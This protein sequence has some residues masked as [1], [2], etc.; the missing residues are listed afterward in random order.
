MAVSF[1]ITGT[2]TG[3]GKTHATIALMEQFKKQGYQVAGMKP[4]ASGAEQKN[5]SLINEDAALI[6]NACSNPTDYGLINPA[7][8]ELPVAPHIA[9]SQSGQNIN[10]EKIKECFD[11]L[12][13][14]ND[15]VIVEGAGGW[16]VPLSESENM[17]DL[18]K[19]LG[20]PVVLVVGF[21]LGCINHAI[22]TAELIK[23]DGLKLIGWLKNQLESGYLFEKD[24]EIT[25]RNTIPGPFLGA[26]GFDSGSG[27][28]NQFCLEILSLDSGSL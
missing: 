16:R 27:G 22:M 1:F 25:L 21:R 19:K 2:D 26:L 13:S 23:K 6:M 14:N 11:Q 8:F 20:L 24:T 12:A 15:I 5:G 28:L 10:L 3:I 18:V 7:V 9:A 17:A 4:I